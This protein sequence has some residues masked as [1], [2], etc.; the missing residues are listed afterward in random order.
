MIHTLLEI[1]QRYLVCDGKV[2][3]VLLTCEVF[4]QLSEN[5][6]FESDEQLS[7]GTSTVHRNKS[8]LICCFT[9]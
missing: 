9:L 5:L 1:S 8:W 3:E 2:D 6:L 4:R 7:K